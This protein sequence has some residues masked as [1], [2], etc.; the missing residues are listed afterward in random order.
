MAT[1]VLVIGTANMAAYV[2]SFLTTAGPGRLSSLDRGKSFQLWK[3]F[4]SP[5][6]GS[7]VTCS[8]VTSLVLLV[9]SY[10]GQT[11]SVL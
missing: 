1:L 8:T 6:L 2:R 3:S 5:T 4:R 11:V 10:P 9:S 7:W